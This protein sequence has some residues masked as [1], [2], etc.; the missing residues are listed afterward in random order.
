MEQKSSSEVEIIPVSKVKPVNR[1]KK[2]TKDLNLTATQLPARNTTRPFQTPINDSYTPGLF[3]PE[4]PSIPTSVKSTS[5]TAD[6][7]SKA[8][9]K[10]RLPTTKELS[11]FCKFITIIQVQGCSQK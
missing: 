10:Q 9:R 5:P 7:I 2:S 4:T 3:Q 1:N 8:L 11:S 6:R